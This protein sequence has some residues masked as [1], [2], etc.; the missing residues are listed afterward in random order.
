M[1]TPRCLTTFSK[2]P[3]GV[4]LGTSPAVLD[5]IA[6]PEVQVAIWTP[7]W[8]ENVRAEIARTPAAA[9]TSLPEA[10]GWKRNEMD[11]DPDPR[12]YSLDMRDKGRDTTPVWRKRLP[13]TAAFN[14]MAEALG[15]MT[16]A[17]VRQTGH[18]QLEL[19]AMPNI[20]SHPDI[21]P[22]PITHKDELLSIKAFANCAGSTT[23]GVATHRNSAANWCENLR[24]RDYPEETFSLPR[25]SFALWK[26][27]KSNFPFHH[28]WPVN[29]KPEFRFTA[30]VVQRNRLK[31]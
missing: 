9:Y 29:E 4:R 22:E 25:H 18:R 16:T 20:Y 21:C 30:Q 27:T 19:W 1:E 3:T 11:I 5:E 15:V 6:D 8:S 23:I 10:R 17:Y 14:H 13:P 12:I 28:A 7:P 2:M 31:F 24:H 26:G